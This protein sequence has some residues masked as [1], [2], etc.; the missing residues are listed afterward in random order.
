MLLRPRKELVLVTVLLNPADPYKGNWDLII[1]LDYDAII[2]DLGDNKAMVVVENKYMKPLMLSLAHRGIKVERQEAPK[3]S[4]QGV[5]AFGSQYRFQ[6]CWKGW[7]VNAQ[8][9][10]A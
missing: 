3:Q 5:D 9:V 4:F 7:L 10:L 6:P 2:M 1:S 8:L